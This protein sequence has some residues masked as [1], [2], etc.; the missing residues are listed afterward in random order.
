MIDVWLRKHVGVV[1]HVVI[2]HVYV[3]VG[4][5]IR[6]III[7]HVAIGHVGAEGIGS[8]HIVTKHAGIIVRA[9]MVIH[10]W[11]EHVV[12]RS[13]LSVIVGEYVGKSICAASLVILLERNANIRTSHRVIGRL[14]QD[15]ARIDIVDHIGVIVVGEDQGQTVDWRLE[16]PPSTL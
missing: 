16:L 14:R 7:Q 8:V 4:I 15:N 5:L 3:I 11:T 1:C 9:W 12:I 6:E 13:P 2:E 10:G